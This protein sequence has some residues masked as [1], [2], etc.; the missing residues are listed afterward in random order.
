MTNFD[1]RP[2]LDIRP[3]HEGDRQAIYDI[4]MTSG[5]FAQEDADCVDGMFEETW[6]EG[7]DDPDNYRWLCCLDDGRVAGFVCFGPESL[8]QDTWDLFWIC[9][10]PAMRGRG[11]G[12]ALIT[13]AEEEARAAGGRVMVIYTSSAEKYTAARRL[14]AGAGFVRTAVVPDYY[15]DGEDLNVYWKRLAGRAPAGAP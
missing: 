12:R 13:A 11:A 7:R 10:V 14:Y 6:G 4:L 2:G 3:S 8:T 9:L 5:L 1:E 15:A